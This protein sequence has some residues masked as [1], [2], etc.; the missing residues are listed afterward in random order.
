MEQNTSPT[1]QVTASGKVVVTNAKDASTPI[2]V[3]SWKGSG[4]QCK[5]YR[6]IGWRRKSNRE[7]KP[8][9][10]VQLRQNSRRAFLRRRAQRVITPIYS[11]AEFISE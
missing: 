1:I 7:A 3:L 9:C 8:I 10:V 4:Y 2:M 6:F 11:Q 5:R